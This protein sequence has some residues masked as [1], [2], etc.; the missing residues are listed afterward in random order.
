MWLDQ[1]VSY[2]DAMSSTE[3]TWLA[4]GFLGQSMFLHALFLPV[5]LQRTGTP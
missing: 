4:I 2:F 1:L 3:I 5:D